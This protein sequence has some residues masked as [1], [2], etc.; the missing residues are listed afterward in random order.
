M[1]EAFKYALKVRKLKNLEIKRL[2]LRDKQDALRDQ[3]LKVQSS[4]ESL[5]AEIGSK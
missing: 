5:K 3:K 2:K 1:W 4:Y